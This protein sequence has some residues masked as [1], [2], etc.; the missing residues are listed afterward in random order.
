LAFPEDPG[1][2]ARNARLFWRSE[3]DPGVV[4]VDALGAA[5]DPDALDVRR[6]GARALVLRDGPAKEQLLLR[7][8]SR[9]LRLE[10]CSGTLLAGPVRLRYRIEGLAELS[11]KLMTLRR[12][13]ALRRLGRFPANL[14]PAERRAARW[15]LLIRALDALAA[16][17]SHR[18]IAA[19]LFGERRTDSEWRTHSDYL[20]LRVQRLARTAS[21]LVDGGYLALL[22]ERR[23]L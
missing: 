18:E 14:F 21:A 12:L 19:G 10:V 22:G 17:A 3:R 8:G 23:Q 4:R 9:T 13:V 6:I 7:D 2:S 11:P 5:S 16:G 20:R 1:R 15:T